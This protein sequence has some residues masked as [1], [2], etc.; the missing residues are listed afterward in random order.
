MT[1]GL[2]LKFSQNPKLKTCLLKTGSKHI[3]EASVWDKI[4][5]IGLSV[6]DP[7]TANADQWC[8]LNLLGKALMRVRMELQDKKE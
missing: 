3:A 1:I 2:W 6:S 8:G 4:W 5:G 7:R